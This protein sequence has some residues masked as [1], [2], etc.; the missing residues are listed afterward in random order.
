MDKKV[1]NVLSTNAQPSEIGTTKRKQR[2]GSFIDVNCPEAVISYS[3][4][5]GG[6][7]CNDQLRQF[8]HV[9]TKSRKCYRYLFWFLFELAA[10]NAYII[11]RDN[12]DQPI[13]L[14]NYRILLAEQLIGTYNSRLRP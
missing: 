14:R 8:Y 7:D 13:L 1:V 5:M 10:T 3:K 6:V 12:S 9:R 4:Y 2:D 11:F